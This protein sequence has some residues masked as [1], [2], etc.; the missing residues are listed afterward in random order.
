MELNQSD[1]SATFRDVVDIRKS[2]S[3]ARHSDTAL[4]IGNTN[5]ASHTA[6]MQLMSGNAGYSNIYLGD[7]NSYSQGGFVYEHSSD[8]L[9]FRNK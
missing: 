6:Q 8:K 9:Y 1:S 7:T 3:N 5:A 4:Y 2:G